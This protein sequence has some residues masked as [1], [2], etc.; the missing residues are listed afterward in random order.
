MFAKLC[1]GGAKNAVATPEG[2]LTSEELAGAAGVV[3]ASLAGHDSVLVWSTPRLAT[4]VGV[5]GALAA[6]TPIVPLNPKSGATELEH[7]LAD[8]RP[9]ALL[10][11][12]DDPIPESLA[13]LKRV[14]V[15]AAATRGSLPRTDIDDRPGLILYTSGTTG[16][17][18]GVVVSRQAIAANIEALAAVWE[19]SDADIL[20]HALPLFHV[21]GLVLGVLGPLLL[22]SE[23]RHTQSFGVE[24][25]CA[26]LRGGATLHFGVPTMYHRLAAAAE[27][28]PS[29]AAA[30]G[31]A[32]LLVSGSAAL[33]AADHESILRHSG[34]SIIER[35]GMTE[36]LIITSMP[37]EGD[38]RAGY[39]GRPL[40]GVRIRV[41]DEDGAEVPADGESMGSILVSSPSLMAGYLNKSEA[42]AAVRDGSYF[43]TGDLGTTSP[44]G[45]LRLIGRASVDLIKS[46]GFR[47]GAGEIEAALVSHPAVA[48]AAV[49]GAPDDDL[50][51]RIV[52]WVVTAEGAS[53]D[54]GEL[55]DHVAA[56]LTPHKRPRDVHFTATLPRN[57]LGKVQKQRLIT[58]FAKAL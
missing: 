12:E 53:V 42:T 51:Q 33:P 18:K 29:C 27:C 28:D 26:A 11:G 21:H 15:D 47:I 39:V 31:S 2:A 58:T 35:Y 3:A 24:T 38:R 37:L 25:T 45:L 49:V 9:S 46:G 57:A 41:V 1:E 16:P 13:G 56:E 54:A 23:V 7:I 20:T 43:R 55:I 40:P 32:R 52:A 19:W 6:G 22:G 50:G 34:Q 10:A 36:T 30:L 44:D 48:E 14:V 8:A 5:V 17:P 4:I